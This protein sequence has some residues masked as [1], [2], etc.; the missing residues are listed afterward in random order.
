MLQTCL[1]F[2]I[3]NIMYRVKCNYVMLA[4][5]GHSG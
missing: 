4:A 1:Y 5:Y 3:R 2:W